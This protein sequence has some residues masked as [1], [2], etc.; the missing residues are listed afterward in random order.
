M[1]DI[2]KLGNRLAATI[3]LVIA[4]AVAVIVIAGAID[5]I[6]IVWNRVT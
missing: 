1:F 5:I 6:H 4:S 2:D 3:G